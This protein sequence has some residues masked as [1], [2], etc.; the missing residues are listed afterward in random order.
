M[1]SILI[2]CIDLTEIERE[3]FVERDDSYFYACSIIVMKSLFTLGFRTSK[4]SFSAKKYSVWIIVFS[5]I[6]IAS[7][8]QPSQTQ[9]GSMILKIPRITR[10]GL[11]SELIDQN[12]IVATVKG[13]L[14]NYSCTKRNE[15]VSINMTQFDLIWPRSKLNP[16]PRF[17]GTITERVFWKK[18]QNHRWWHHS[19]DLGNEN[20]MSR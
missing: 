11:N 10:L 18:I 5:L 12:E 3:S 7:Q 19:W 14:D 1:G 20:Y 6:T 17:F 8:T 13:Y 16:Y 4:I 15:G 2:F 9:N